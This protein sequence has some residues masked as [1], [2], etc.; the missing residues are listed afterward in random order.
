MSHPHHISHLSIDENG[1]I[2]PSKASASASAEKIP[3]SKKCRQLLDE[4]QFTDLSNGI[5]SHSSGQKYLT[6]DDID[7]DAVQDLPKSDKLSDLLRAVIAEIRRMGGPS[8]RE[9]NANDNDNDADGDEGE[10]KAV[11]NKR[12]GRRVKGRVAKLEEQRRLRQE[13]EAQKEKENEIDDDNDEQDASEDSGVNENEDIEVKNSENDSNDDMS[14]DMRLANTF[15]TLR[16]LITVLRPILDHPHHNDTSLKM[17]VGPKKKK[18]DFYMISTHTF[19]P[20]SKGSWNDTR[21][22]FFRML[23]E[24]EAGL[25]HKV[26]KRTNDNSEYVFNVREWTVSLFNHEQLSSQEYVLKKCIGE[27]LLEACK[28][29]N[30]VSH[31]FNDALVKRFQNDDE[32]KQRMLQDSIRNLQKKLSKTL[33]RIFPDVHLS[34]Y[35]SCLSGLALE[36]SHDVDVSVY[37][38]QLDLL[39]QDFDA[40]VISAR[41]YESKMKRVLYRIKGSLQR[42]DSFVDVFAITHARVP[43]IKGTDIRARN[44]Y[45]EDGSL[46]FDMCFLNDIAVVNSSLLREYSLF[47]NRV[48]MLMLSVKSFAKLNN[49]AS[50]ANGTLSSYSWLNLVVFYLQVIGFLP[51]LQCP[52]LMEKHGFKPDPKGNRWHCIN[53]LETFYLTEKIVSNGKIWKQSHLCEDINLPVLLYGFFSFYCTVFPQQTIAA[54]IRLGQMTLQKTSFKDSSKLWRM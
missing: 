38:P 22:S 42:S 6:K 25:G 40:G 37:I 35:G 21:V 12:R 32:K 11:Q 39:K 33:Q 9:N 30:H 16:V 13:Q 44:P 45:E 5:F 3:I 26:M 27:D 10:M 34:V 24:V 31:K 28:T 52:K 17:K 53:S 46:S 49:I 1:W 18:V 2:F 19:S 23:N 29:S 47:D 43:V 41:E 51:T 20:L 48:R 54:S 8:S 4:L 15:N 14:S 36:G 50:A 7:L